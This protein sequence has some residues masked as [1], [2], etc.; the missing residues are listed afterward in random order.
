MGNTTNTTSTESAARDSDAES[1][2]AHTAAIQPLHRAAWRG[3][4]VTDYQVGACVW[5]WDHYNTAAIVG[6]GSRPGTW[7]VE[8][9]SADGAI[10]RFTYPVS[11]LRP[12]LR[13]M[14]FTWAARS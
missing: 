14:V 6:P 9:Q 5:M 7:A 8:T 10:D 11:Q 2:N 4:V 12:A 13:P 1:L 3:P